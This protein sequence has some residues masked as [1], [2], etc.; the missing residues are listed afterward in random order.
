[1]THSPVRNFAWDGSGYGAFEI[2]GRISGADFLENVNQAATQYRS[3]HRMR[4]DATLEVA[5]PEWV[6]DAI[7]ADLLRQGRLEVVRDVCDPVGHAPPP[8]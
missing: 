7:R 8:T 1:M 2:V 4:R 5:F 6:Y 3:R